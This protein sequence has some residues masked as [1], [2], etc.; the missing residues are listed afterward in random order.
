MITMCMDCLVLAKV[1]DFLP[2]KTHN[3][4]SFS[5][6]YI[7]LGVYVIS[8]CLY[9]MCI[10]YNEFQVTVKQMIKVHFFSIWKLY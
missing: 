6:V 7:N 9:V 1:L 4:E 10:V 2:L 8:P 5:N 3:K